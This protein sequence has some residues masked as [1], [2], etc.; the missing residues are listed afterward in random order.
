MGEQVA[1]EDAA[2]TLPSSAGT[3]VFSGVGGGGTP[4]WATAADGNRI[5]YGTAGQG[6]LLIAFVHGGMCDRTYWAAQMADLASTYRVLSLDLPG[7][8]ESGGTRSQWSIEGFGDDVAR[9][10]EAAEAAQVV[11]VGHSLGGPVVV[12]ATRR[13]GS[14][15]AGVVLVDILHQP[16]FRA[17]P[18]PQM[19]LAGVK[20]AMRRGMFTPD[21]DT[22]TR[23]RIIDAMT[24]APPQVAGP[25]RQ[26]F[27]AYDAPASLQAI[28]GAPLSMILSDLRPI[29]ATEIRALHPGARILV[30]KGAGHFMMI[31]AP[32]TFNALLRSE[33][34]VMTGRVGAL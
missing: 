33:V 6:G 27:A 14:R 26:A 10:V 13:L 22:A 18:P 15:V 23:D 32:A 7:H 1:P 30:V 8:G 20:A 24:S 12:E 3:G 21:A 5:R 28:A 17:P 19:D 31:D 9:T 11:L 2:S 4:A 16:R 25:V 29:D 34:L